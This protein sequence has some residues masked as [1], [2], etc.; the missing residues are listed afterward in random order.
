[1]LTADVSSSSHNATSLYGT[2]SSGSGNVMTG[3]VRFVLFPLLSLSHFALQSLGGW[4]RLG[5]ETERS[6]RGHLV[7]GWE[8]RRADTRPCDLEHTRERKG[9]NHRPLHLIRQ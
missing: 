5:E 4:V 6:S 8:T 9:G 2:W 7:D 3:M 1:M